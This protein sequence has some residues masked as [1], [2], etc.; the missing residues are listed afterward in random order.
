M[1]SL[2]SSQAVKVD[3][4]EIKEWLDWYSEFCKVN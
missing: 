4:T 1:P 2:T 3:D